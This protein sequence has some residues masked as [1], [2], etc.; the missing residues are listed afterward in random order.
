MVGVDYSSLPLGEGRREGGR[1]DEVYSYDANGNR[2]NPGYV[3]GEHN[4][5]LSDGTYNYEY[6]PEG[7]RTKRTE[8]A[9]GAV[10]EYVW[11]HRNRLVEVIERASEDGPVV[12]SVRYLYDSQDRW[13]GRVLD[14][15]GDGP[16][17]AVASYFVYDIGTPEGRVTPDPAARAGQMLLELDAQ[18]RVTHRYLWGPAVD[19][20][21]ADEQ[22]FPLPVGEGQ[23]EGLAAV[24]GGG[25]A[26]AQGEGPNLTP[27]GTV[28]WPLTD[29]LG[30]V[31]DLAR[32]NPDTDRTTIVNHL[33][34]D[35]FGQ[36][37]GQSNPAVTTLFAFTG[38]PLDPA[39]GLQNHLHRWY[40][41]AMGRWLSEDPIG[42]HAAEA[43]PY[44][45][46]GN[47][48]GI[49]V[50]RSGLIL[51]TLWDAANIGLDLVSLGRN[52]YHGDLKGAAVD[53]GG[54]VVDVA[55]TLIP[56]VP[57]G[58]GAGI[59]A[60]RA[61]AKA[62][63]KAADAARAVDKAA[64]AARAVDK[65]A[66]AARV[67]RGATGQ[68]YHAISAKVHKALEKHPTLSG[69]YRRRDPRLVSRAADKEAHYGYQTWRRDL[70]E[71]VVDW[72][73]SPENQQATVEEFERFLRSLYDRPE[74]RKRF[75]EGLPK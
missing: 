68:L 42:F 38:R 54:L 28:V 35:A 16:A 4:R 45:Y 8:I 48:P 3:T 63:D 25:Q 53:A 2:T 11:D 40:D 26:R 61:A 50:D 21:L 13:I 56:G 43:N 27:V 31:R 55:A 20:I 69:A 19:Q 57:G 75:P 64:D 30:T 58:A 52:L 47:S 24:Q 41:P 71:Q 60:A 22:V 33:T 72:L 36:M 73:E 46:C 7:N 34:Y 59:K 49:C 67:A 17:E 14:A 23:G 51:E 44:R 1:A 62:A 39:T 66:D 32:Y 70:D 6:D 9:T 5:L 65:A 37:T 29:H 15:D 18:G 74:M 10:T 12:Q